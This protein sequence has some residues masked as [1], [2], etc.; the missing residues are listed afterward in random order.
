[1]V[2]P[3]DPQQL[4]AGKKAVDELF[5]KVIEWDGKITG[6]H[7]IGLAKLPWWE[8]GTSSEERELHRRVKQAL[9]P[10]GIMNPGKFV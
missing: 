1:M 10:N 3:D 5:R 7:G 2:V 4:E 8:M 6:E 9:D